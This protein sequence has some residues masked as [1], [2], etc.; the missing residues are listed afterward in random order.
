MPSSNLVKV[1]LKL[2]LGSRLRLGLRL[3][4]R[5]RLGMGLVSVGVQLFSLM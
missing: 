1:R 5:L 3:G 4:L 2:R